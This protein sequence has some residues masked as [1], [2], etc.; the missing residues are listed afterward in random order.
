MGVGTMKSGTTW[1]WTLLTGHPAIVS[2]REAQAAAQPRSHDPRTQ[3]R[4]I[5][6]AKEIDFFNHFGAVEDINP[7][8]YHRYFPRPDH[9]IAGEWTPRYIYDWW[10]PPMLKA[11]AAQAKLLVLLRDPL[12][13]LASALGFHRALSPHQHPATAIN[14]QFHHAL[15]GQQL[16]RLQD[17]FPREQILVLQYE[18]CV[19]DPQGQARRT[20]EFLGVEP[21]AWQ[22]DLAARRQVGPSFPKPELNQATREAFCRAIAPDITQLLRDFPEIDTTLWPSIDHL[23]LR[24]C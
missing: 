2:P 7:A 19:A 4:Q 16:H 22:P 10:T 18:Q 17:S 6:R 11:V 12:E 20:F 1:W 3:Q 9:T 24:C 5:Y 15:Y 14:H 13:R 8:D 23:P 21:E